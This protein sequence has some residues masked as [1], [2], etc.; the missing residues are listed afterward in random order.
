MYFK[1]LE[2]VALNHQEVNYVEIVG[3]FNGFNAF[4]ECF[5]PT[6]VHKEHFAERLYK[7]IKKMSDPIERKTIHRSPLTLLSNRCSLFAPYLLDDFHYWHNLLLTKLMALQLEDRKVA[8]SLLHSLHREIAHQ[9]IDPNADRAK[10]VAI[11][12]YLQKF[13]EEAIQSYAQ[14]KVRLAI[15]GI[16]LI[17]E[18]CKQLLP[19][20]EVGRLLHSVLQR[21]ESAAN[22]INDMR[23][24]QIEYLPDYIESVSKI[25][26]HMEQLPGI[27]LQM[28]QDF[29]V[30]IIRNFNLLSRA[31]HATTVNTLRRA[32]DNF[33]RLGDT[34]LDDMLETIVMRGVCWTCSHKLPFDV[35]NDWDVDDDW[36]HH[37]TYKSFLPLWSGLIRE[38]DQCTPSELAVVQKIYDHLMRTLFKILDKLDLST[39]KRVHRDATGV[40]QELIFC[41]PNYDLEAVCD[42]DIHVFINLV[43][44]YRDVLKAQSMSSQINHFSKWLNRF[45]DEMVSRSLQHPVISGF[46]KLIHV[47]FRTADQLHIAFD[48][49]I[50]DEN[51]HLYGKIRYYL[52]RLIERANQNSGEL[53]LSCIMVL[54]AMP[55]VM[56]SKYIRNMLP[57]FRCAFDI[58]RSSANLFI[59]RM[60]LRTLERYLRSINRTLEEGDQFLKDVLPHLSSYLNGLTNDI[61]DDATD[62]KSRRPKRKTRNK[63]AHQ[64]SDNE[65][66]EF[67]KQIFLLLGKLEPSQCLYMTAKDSDGMDLVKWGPSIAFGLDLH[68]FNVLP[69]LVVD[70]LLPRLC[71]LAESSTNRQIKVSACEFMHAT[72]LYIVGTYH[73]RGEFWRKLCDLMLCLGCDTDTG[74]KQMFEPLIMQIMRHMSKNVGNNEAGVKILFQCL[75][76]AISHT[77]SLA[78]RA[79]AARALHELSFWTI[80]DWDPIQSPVLPHNIN[81]L[82]TN[83]KMFSADMCNEKRFGAALAFNNIYRV[84]R[85]QEHIVSVYWLDLLHDFCINFKLTESHA[86]D[87]MDGQTDLTQI[88]C[89]LDHFLRV[90]RER[91]HIFNQPNENRIQPLP[92]AGTL[93][94]DAVT[95]ML[96]ECNS[97]LNAYR[98]KMMHLVLSLA[99]CIDGYA[100]AMAFMRDV[101]T[102]LSLVQLCENGI[103]EN[104]VVPM[105]ERIDYYQLDE[106]LHGLQTSLNCYIWC[107]ENNFINTANDI[108]THGDLFEALAHYFDVVMN[109]NVSELIEAEYVHT[110]KLDKMDAMKSDIFLQTLHF[111]N[112]IMSWQFADVRIWGSQQLIEAIVTAVFEPHRLACNT[113]DPEYL[114][115]LIAT[116]EQFIINVDRHR[117]FYTRGMLFRRLNDV[118]VHKYERLK[119]LIELKDFIDYDKIL[120][121]DVNCVIGI[122]LIC[123]LT[124]VKRIE[125]S[126]TIGECI[127]VVAHNILY[128]LFNG[129]KEHIDDR[130]YV[131]TLTPDLSQFTNQMLRICFFR[132]EIHTNLI[133]LLLNSSILWSRDTLKSV[134]HGKQFLI[135]HK[136]TIYA[137]FLE[138]Y[139]I[140]IE[141]LVTKISTA[142]MLY[143]L[144]MLIDFVDY[145]YKYSAR[146]VNKLK[147]LSNTLLDKW[148]RIIQPNVINIGRTSTLLELMEKIA[149]I[150]PMELV[151]ISK[152]VPNF[153]QWLLG[154]IRQELDYPI[155]LKTQ[156]ISLLPCMVNAQ[157]IEYADVQNA[158]EM[159][160][161][162][163]LP[164]QT[165]ELTSGS[166]EFTAVKNAFQAVLK[167]FRASKSPVLLRFLMNC[168]MAEEKHFMHHQIMTN[169]EQATRSLSKDEC[170][171]CLDMVFGVFNSE[172]LEPRFRITV[173]ERFLKPMLRAAS[174]DGANEFYKAHIRTILELC[175]CECRTDVNDF[176]LEH[177]FTS[178]IGGFEL[179][180]LLVAVVPAEQIEDKNGAIPIAA[181]E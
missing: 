155:E 89:S 87:S 61:L 126:P 46:M 172:Q 16:G 21:I 43:E 164:L 90:L 154:I 57:I 74:I 121:D 13:F 153:D 100:S 108:V 68:G 32:F 167:A 160:R 49:N 129:I 170:M 177:A 81:A 66:L 117:Q 139:E 27:Q 28:I 42:K 145:A 63:A 9:L 148:S 80:K 77:Q 130:D 76:N 8:I 175:K 7:C 123:K 161:S 45:L 72:I 37:I 19:A 71:T 141:I 135:L 119:V 156:A 92:F 162:K 26:V 54:L 180:E 113:K 29:I 152:A 144:Q 91:K 35:N 111:L 106:Y 143:I 55:T 140:V 88:S 51:S 34:L 124:K 23:R 24:S 115:K 86:N 127:N 132:D 33:A 6:D 20:Y 31:E 85:E 40:E 56:L 83:L 105:D 158:L 96:D 12:Q 146:D 47:A 97:V 67:Q 78:T 84:L 3:A 107:I 104:W 134:K 4:L 98:S 174:N 25:M 181:G 62:L 114:R 22:A 10:C 95:W 82:L 133:D 102:G 168:T 15:V 125:F 79:L 151:E 165:T 41:D 101:K 30:A 52:D 163:Y 131:R 178:R 116:I 93:L 136:H 94:K 103:P 171:V 44:F 169:I 18:P 159:F 110:D 75:M 5:T 147:M 118:F 150:C 142:N 69:S 59:A 120:A 137:Y 53:Q 64:S 176:K 112:R 122:Q 11:L 60:A 48:H 38:N 157:T 128:D 73:H 17:A 36:R 39:Q 2:V 14:Y 179:L 50:I 65:L 1:S 173:L 149:M 99:P 138:R 70:S 58:G 166:T 109:K